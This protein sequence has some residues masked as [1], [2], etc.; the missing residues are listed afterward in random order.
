MLIGC[1]VGH[2]RKMNFNYIYAVT[3]SK[4]AIIIQNR[5]CPCAILCKQWISLGSSQ[6][7]PKCD[8][9]NDYERGREQT[10]KPYYAVYKSMVCLHFEY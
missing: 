9:R 5:D 2:I 8:V 1:K 7:N 3:S 4:L 10:R 6:K